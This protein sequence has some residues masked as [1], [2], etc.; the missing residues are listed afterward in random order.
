MT[1]LDFPATW[2]NREVIL[3]KLRARLRPG[4]RVLEVASGSGQHVSFFAEQMPRVWF[5]P[6]DV[7]PEHLASISAWARHAGAGNVAE[8]LLLDARGEWP[9]ERYDAVLCINLIHISPW[10]VTEALIPAA[11]SNLTRGGWLYLYGAYQRNGEHTSESNRAFDAGL[12]QQNPA[13]GVR[14]LEEVERLAGAHGFGP[15]EVHQMP[16]NNLSVFFD[17]VTEPKQN[18]GF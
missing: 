4:Q 9:A 15:A 3:E 14:H 1:M 2:R 8:P 5:Q 16:A 10:S 7:E 6:S 13:W 17:K 18:G 12:R 11:A